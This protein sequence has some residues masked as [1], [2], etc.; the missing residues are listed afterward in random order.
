MTVFLIR[1]S[2]FVRFLYAL[3]KSCKAA[4]DTQTKGLKLSSQN[5]HKL[6]HHASIG[7]SDQLPKLPVPC[8]LVSKSMDSDAKEKIEITEDLEWW[9]VLQVGDEMLFGV[10]LDVV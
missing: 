7:F 8:S 5:T 9:G 4:M 6:A 2:K 1:R 3:D 10:D